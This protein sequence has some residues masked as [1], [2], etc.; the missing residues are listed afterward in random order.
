MKERGEIIQKVA[1]LAGQ[2]PAVGPALQNGIETVQLWVAPTEQQQRQL[3]VL[4]R[5][6]QSRTNEIFFNSRLSDQQA[7]NQLEAHNRIYKERL[8]EIK[9][10]TSNI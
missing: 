6:D 2:V 8:N 10:G 3:E 7:A 9:K 4:G 1:E 5:W